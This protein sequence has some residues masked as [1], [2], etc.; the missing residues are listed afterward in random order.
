MHLLK[1]PKAGDFGKGVAVVAHEIHNLAEQSK[2]AHGK[3]P[4]YSD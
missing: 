2:Q 3:H 1:R 4:Y